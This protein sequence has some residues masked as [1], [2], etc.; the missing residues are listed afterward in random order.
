M[1]G[2][3]R[4]KPGILKPGGPKFLLRK[5][6]FDPSKFITPEELDEISKKYVG[7]DAD[8]ATLQHL[9][10]D[11][12]AVYAERGIVT[13]IATLPEQDANGGI[14]RVKLTEGRLQKTT[15]EGN[16]QTSTLSILERVKEPEGEILD[17]PKL[18][19]DVRRARLRSSSGRS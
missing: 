6:Q 11:I 4:E 16:K 15:I 9:A 8:I 19:R 2:G 13:G 10:A 5:V 1:I 12:N 7:K 17:V 18:N 3:V 14:V